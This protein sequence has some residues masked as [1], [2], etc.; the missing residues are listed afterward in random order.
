M[1]DEAWRTIYDG[2]EI[3]KSYGVDRSDLFGPDW[4]CRRFAADVGSTVA[5]NIRSEWHAGC[6]TGCGIREAHGADADSHLARRSLPGA[7][8]LSVRQQYP[9]KALATSSLDGARP[10]CARTDHW[11]LCTGDELQNEY[12]RAKRN[13]RDHVVCPFVS[14]LPGEGLHSYP[15]ERSR[16]PSRVDDSDVWGRSGCGDDA[17]DRRD[18]LCISPAHA[19]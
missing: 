19:T 8:A 11:N 3:G 1:M 12:R 2:N 17:S 7:G 10:S 15:S 16:S 5:G 14:D 4:G 18:V 6:V 9:A 13:G